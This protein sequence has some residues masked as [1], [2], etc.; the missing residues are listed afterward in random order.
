NRAVIQA[1]FSPEVLEEGSNSNTLELDPETVLVVRSKEHL[2][3][4][5]LPLESVA[6]SI[7]AQLVK[8]HATAAAKTKGEALLAGLRDGK[9]PL[10]AK[11]DGRDWKS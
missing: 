8:E 6:S 10:A 11:Q 7:R 3:P 4:Q 1:A 5:Q 2:Q 9:I